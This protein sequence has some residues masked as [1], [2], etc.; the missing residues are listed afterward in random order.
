MIKRQVLSQ[1]FAFWLVQEVL[2]GEEET[3]EEL[4]P[5]ADKEFYAILA[6]LLAAIATI[7]LTIG[8]FSIV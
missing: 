3:L 7:A 1:P 2:S 6:M 4:K 8:P 5:I